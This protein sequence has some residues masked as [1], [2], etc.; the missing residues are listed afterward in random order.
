LSKNNRPQTDHVIKSHYFMSHHLDLPV[1]C[2]VSLHYDPAARSYVNGGFRRVRVG[3][4][5]SFLVCLS[6][7]MVAMTA[8]MTDGH[9]LALLMATTVIIYLASCKAGR[10]AGRQAG[11]QAGRQAGRQALTLFQ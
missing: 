7:V 8:S 1:F 10:Q 4:L 11:W 3:H 9:R 6:L 2:H 5:S